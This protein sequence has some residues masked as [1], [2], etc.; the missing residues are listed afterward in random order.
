MRAIPAGTPCTQTSRQENP[1]SACACADDRACYQSARAAA[2]RRPSPQLKR[3]A[4]GLPGAVPLHTLYRLPNVLR[5]PA[6]RGGVEVVGAAVK[7]LLTLLLHDHVAIPALGAF[8][9]VV[10]PGRWS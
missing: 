1:K 5:V 2:Q 10:G 4:P 8:V 7:D 3:T 6:R 9:D